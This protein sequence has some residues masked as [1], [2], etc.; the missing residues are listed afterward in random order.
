MI[1]LLQDYVAARAG[2]RPEAVAVVSGAASL[3]Y[4]GLEARSN[5]LARLLRDNGCFRGDRVCL[6]APKSALSIV[7]ILGI[8]KADCIYVPLDPSSPAP[9]A[10]EHR[11]P[12]QVFR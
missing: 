11:S 2:H 3:T 4:G 7:A 1:K 6:L 9:R 8:Y 10:T 5:Q 12:D